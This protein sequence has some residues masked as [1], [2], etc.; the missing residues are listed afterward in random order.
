MKFK[1]NKKYPIT[2]LD[3]QLFKNCLVSLRD[4][5]GELNKDGMIVYYAPPAGVKKAIKIEHPDLGNI[6]INKT[7]LC[8]TRKTKEMAVMHHYS[9][10]KNID[11]K[12]LY[13]ILENVK[14]VKMSTTLSSGDNEFMKIIMVEDSNSQVLLVEKNALSIY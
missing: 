1:L 2:D 9:F 5:Y 6:C 7:S 3:M 10:K 12:K 11:I 13:A 8:F 4:G 14:D